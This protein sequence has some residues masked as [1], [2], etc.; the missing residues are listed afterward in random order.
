MEL[1]ITGDLVS[2]QSNIDLFNI[3]DVNTLLGKNLQVL[4]NQADIR[5]FN[6]EAPLIDQ[7]PYYIECEAHRELLLSGIKGGFTI[8]G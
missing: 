1:L 5:I 7:E 4:W 6:L 8:E 3:A 2:T